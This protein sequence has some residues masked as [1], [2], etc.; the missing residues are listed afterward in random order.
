M[1]DSVGDGAGG[2]GACEG[3]EGEDGDGRGTHDDVM[4]VEGEGEG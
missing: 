4:V 3:G 1:A 2:D